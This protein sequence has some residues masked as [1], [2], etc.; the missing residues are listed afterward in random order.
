MRLAEMSADA[1]GFAKPD[2]FDD[3]VPVKDR[4]NTATIGGIRA[5]ECGVGV[6][7]DTGK[8]TLILGIRD[9]RRHCEHAG[10]QTSGFPGHDASLGPLAHQT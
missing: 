4:R 2:I 5:A 9:N 8:E 7:V 3:A 10:Q 6:H 1:D